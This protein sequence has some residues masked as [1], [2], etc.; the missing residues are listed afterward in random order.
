VLSFESFRDLVLGFAG[1]VIVSGLYAVTR[2]QRS[3]IL[4]HLG[5]RRATSDAQL[6]ALFATAAE[7]EIAMNARNLLKKYLLIPIDLVQPDD[8][9]CADLGLGAQDGLDA[10]FF[11]RDVEKTLGIKIPDAQA[12][13]MFTL[14]DI[15]T[16]IHANRVVK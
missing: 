12:A 10:N 15:V 4:K 13:E 3:K 14:R 5:D 11:V 6:S 9:L 1:V 16:Y 7:A 8:K 2:S